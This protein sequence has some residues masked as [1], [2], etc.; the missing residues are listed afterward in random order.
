M[1]RLLKSVSFF[2]FK[3]FDAF[4]VMQILSFMN[5]RENLYKIYVRC[6]PFRQNFDYTFEN[7]YTSNYT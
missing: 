3:E 2:A 4:F 7:T 5:I 6:H 1:R